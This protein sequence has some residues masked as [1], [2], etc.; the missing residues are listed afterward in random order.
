VALLIEHE[1]GRSLGAPAGGGDRDD[2]EE[3]GDGGPVRKPLWRGE[4]EPLLLPGC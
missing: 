2:A 1:L 3:Q 4:H